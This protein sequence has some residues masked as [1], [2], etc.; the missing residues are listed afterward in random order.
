MPKKSLSSEEKTEVIRRLL[1]DKKAEDIAVIDVRGKS[2]FTDFFVLCS[3]QTRRHI[4]ALSELLED[5][6]KGRGA[7]I[8]RNTRT[9]GDDDWVVLD[10]F[11]V[12]V[13]IFDP[14]MRSFYGIE[15]LWKRPAKERKRSDGQTD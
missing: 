7:R 4:K 2:N 6:L 13:H 11:D 8:Y 12:I 1:E 15:K 10:C 5:E 9:G 3:A 14:H